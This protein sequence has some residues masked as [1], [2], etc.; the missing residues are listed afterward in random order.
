M[1]KVLEN[2]VIPSQCPVSCVEA[3]Q[4]CGA[5]PAKRQNRLK[6]PPLFSHLS[7]SKEEIKHLNPIGMEQKVGSTL[8]QDLQKLKPRG[9]SREATRALGLPL[10]SP[11]LSHFRQELHHVIKT[12]LCQRLVT[13]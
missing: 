7:T 2:R 3:V 5:P 4:G 8:F 6:L 10:S 12:K 11:F 9:T 13:P 1:W